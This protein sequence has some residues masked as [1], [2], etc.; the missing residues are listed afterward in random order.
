MADTRT[1]RHPEQSAQH[2]ERERGREASRIRDVPGA[3][4]KD[5]L[6]RTK[7][8]I[9]EDRLSMVAAGVAF[10]AFLA[11]F[12][13]LVA[14][15]SLWG[16]FADPAQ[17]QQQIGQLSAALPSSARE[18]IAAQATR[19]AQSSP[20]TLGWATAIS[21]ALTLW[22]TNKGMKGLVEGIGV[23]YDQPDERGF[24]KKNA[25]TLGLTF[26]AIVFGLVVIGMIVAVPIALSFIGLGA[27]A[28]WTIRLARWPLLAAAIIFGLTVI[29]R[30]GPDR[31][32]PKWRW[33]TPGS[34]IAAVL[35]LAASVG[36]SIYVDNFGSYNE[37]YGSVA[38]VA[39]LLMWFYISSF[40]VLLG[41][42]IN[43]ETEKQTR[44]DT[45]VGP[46][47]PMGERDA[48][49][50]DTVAKRPTLH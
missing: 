11:L 23:A 31:D 32:D 20:A 8:Q 35:W 38:A 17:V 1:E 19:I 43:A 6:L 22:S 2:G 49:P 47:K 44:R 48:Y 21:L 30:L 34:V 7:D 18:L 16:L 42:E 46:E 40:I 39:V 10:Y 33:V 36:F 15:I 13:T 5:I 14:V 12:P 3:G 50:A 37:T 29:Y 45:T 41:A 25:V 27:V 26:A 4:W 24:I 28:E 9:R